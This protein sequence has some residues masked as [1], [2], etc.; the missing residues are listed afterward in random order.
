MLLD[1][2]RN[3]Q[4]VV[5]VEAVRPAAESCAGQARD[6]ARGAADRH[7]RGRFDP[8]EYRDEYQEQLKAMLAAKA[9]GKVV[10]F[11][12]AREAR[13]ARLAARGLQASLKARA[14]RRR[15]MAEER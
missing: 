14:A 7:A 10:R 12:K 2:L 11:P 5:E 6:R 9:K 15:A 1:T 3:A 4:E 8:G 13:A